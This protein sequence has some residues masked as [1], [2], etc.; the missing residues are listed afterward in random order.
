MSADYLLV[1]PTH[2]FKGGIA[3]HTTTLAT[4]MAAR[5][6]DVEILSWSR[7]YPKVLYPGELYVP[8]G[9][10]EV[11]PYGR[12]R[13]ALAWNAP[14]GWI[15]EGRR[16]RGTSTIVFVVVN[17]V[18]IVAYLTL[19]WALGSHV[20]RKVALFHNVV[21]HERRRFDEILTKALLRRMDSTIAHTDVEAD[22]AAALG[23]RDRHVTPLPPLLPA[24][25]H[26]DKVLRT[27]PEAPLKVLFFG[28][29]REYKGLDLLVEAIAR[30]PGT[31]LT[32]IGEFW[33]G[34]EPFEEQ[35]ARLGIADRVTLVPGYL[36]ASE[37]PLTF[38]DA[39]LAALP[40]RSATTSAAATL[41]LDCGVPIVAAR[42]GSLK[43]V[44]HDG[45]YGA[46]CEPEDVNSLAEAIATALD[47]A[48]L[49]RW[50]AQIRQRPL[51]W[52]TKWDAYVDMVMDLGPGPRADAA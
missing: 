19:L 10:P 51:A 44:V 11:E 9:K 5:G 26:P 18:Q 1:G 35:I 8:E 36:P 7:Q 45:A 39:D 6:A 34:T 13:R 17:P 21:P 29:V 48:Q 31:E 25:R 47:P 3:Q 12:V 43:D 4:R 37:V 33:G 28:L 22:A 32:V 14:W 15:R 49:A 46:A 41:A 42:V 20:T 2:P 24:R 23:G 40:Y 52:D 50:D 30:V 27:D 16:A 38:R